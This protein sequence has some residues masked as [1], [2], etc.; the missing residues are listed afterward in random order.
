MVKIFKDGRRHIS[1]GRSA[2][3]YHL[4]DPHNNIAT[5]I[6]SV[7]EKRE[8]DF[9]EYYTED[10]E[11]ET[12]NC[13]ICSTPTI[14]NCQKCNIT[15]Y[16][17]KSCQI[18]DWPKHKLKCQSI[19]LLIKKQINAS[20][21]QNISE[22]D[23]QEDW[24]QEQVKTLR[25]P[26]QR[27]PQPVCI[28]ENL[29][30][31]TNFQH[32]QSNE[33]TLNCY[34]DVQDRDSASMQSMN[35]INNKSIIM[36]DQSVSIQNKMNDHIVDQ[37]SNCK[38]NSN[39]LVEHW[40]TEHVKNDDIAI[41]KLAKLPTIMDVLK[42]DEIG[43][44]LFHARISK[45]Q[46]NITLVPD[47]FLED[48][49]NLLDNLKKH[50]LEELSKNSNFRPEVGDL[51]CGE[52]K[53]RKEW[54]RGVV[55]STK[56]AI[57]LATIDESRIFV[58]INYTPMPSKYNSICSMGL[59]CEFPHDNEMLTVIKS[60]IGKFTVVEKSKDVTR[61]KIN[62]NDVLVSV[63]NVLLKTWIPKIEQKSFQYVSLKSGNRP[64]FVVPIV[65]QIVM[66]QYQADN[67]Y[68]RA[69]VTKVKGEII[70]VKYIDYGNDEITTLDKI[71]ILPDD[72]KEVST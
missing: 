11:I 3:F 29:Y 25:H 61:I 17:S 54:F 60:N 6:H 72:L 28:N 37:M 14:Y 46:Y 34:K 31:Q 13:K 12:E 42:V 71:F 66:A 2:V 55:L 67:N 20:S 40:I 64:F 36:K 16:C 38:L 47:R 50:C 63:N 4:P 21:T 65:G 43:L 27:I 62:L 18:K 22:V 39:S 44:I 7:Y 23:I 9:Y 57:K 10:I 45:R 5:Y 32:Q 1:S 52:S 8:K 51:I 53:E 30:N 48:F 70:V 26:K 49:R 56:P 58:P 41:A 69:I 19:P 68:Y 35:V 15:F 59:V 33:G 24:A